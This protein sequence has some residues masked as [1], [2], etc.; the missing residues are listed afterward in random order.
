[1]PS[2][3]VKHWSC[4]NRMCE[5]YY[6]KVECDCSAAFLKQIFIWI[7]IS[8]C[9]GQDVFTVFVLKLKK[10]KVIHFLSQRFILV[11]ILVLTTLLYG[12]VSIWSDFL[13]IVISKSVAIF[14]PL[15]TWPW[16]R[17]RVAKYL[18]ILRHRIKRKCQII[19]Q[20][21]Q[22]HPW[23]IFDVLCCEKGDYSRA[24]YHTEN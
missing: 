7:L 11:V 9:S 13:H 14:S 5:R 16:V 23:R 12:V 22:R 17:S 20:T 6:I 1:M 2:K 18:G 21:I 15:Y 24:L 3:F 10:E 8:R 4:D 19:Q